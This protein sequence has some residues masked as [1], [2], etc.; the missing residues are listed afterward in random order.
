MMCVVNCKNCA[1]TTCPDSPPPRAV[2]ICVACGDVV[3]DTE[4]RYLIDGE[5]VHYDCLHN[6]HKDDRVME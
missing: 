6:Y 2:G 3:Y 5:I 4:E 1:R